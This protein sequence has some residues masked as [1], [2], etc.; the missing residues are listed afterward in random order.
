MANIHNSVNRIKQINQNQSMLFDQTKL[1]LATAPTNDRDAA[2]R[3]M[4]K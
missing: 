3:Q 2:N 1:D 4:K